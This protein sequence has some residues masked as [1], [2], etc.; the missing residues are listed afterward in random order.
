MF[1]RTT[2]QNLEAVPLTH[3]IRLLQEP[4]SQQHSWPAAEAIP[5]VA[6][7]DKTAARFLPF[8]LKI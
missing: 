2:L 8:W 1:R 5:A 4:I 6:Q 3:Q 7:P